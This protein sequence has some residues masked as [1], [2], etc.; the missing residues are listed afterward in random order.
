MLLENERRDVGQLAN[1]IDDRELN[2]R[3]VFR[4]LLHDRGLG[5]TNSDDQIEVP[6][7]ERA[8]SRLDGVWRAGFDIAQ[9]DWQILRGAL[10][11]FPGSSVE[12]PI[13]LSADVKDDADLNLRFVFGSPAS[14]AAGKD[15]CRQYQQGRQG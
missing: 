3:V 4:N 12:R 8:H 6:F 13:V 2:V 9:D 7:G 5:E 15:Q 14:T 11:T 1:A 10:H